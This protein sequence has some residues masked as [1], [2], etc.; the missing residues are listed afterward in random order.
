M[1]D[2]FV[3]DVIATIIK[4]ICLV[5]VSY[6]MAVKWQRAKQA[7]ENPLAAAWPQGL[8]FVALI[9]TQTVVWFRALGKPIGWIG[10]GVAGLLVVAAGV[11]M[12]KQ[13]WHPDR[14]T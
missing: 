7:G 1:N 3:A 2:G 12:L 5:V 14:K 13:T 4:I 9:L 11:G 6:T 10:L 8:M